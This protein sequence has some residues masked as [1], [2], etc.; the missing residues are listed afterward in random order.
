MLSSTIFY[1]VSLVQVKNILYLFDCV[2]AAGSLHIGASTG[3]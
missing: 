1:N 3:L 2:A